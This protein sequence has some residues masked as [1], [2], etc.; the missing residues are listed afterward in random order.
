MDHQY[1]ASE[2]SSYNDYLTSYAGKGA[3]K[4]TKEIWSTTARTAG[5]TSRAGNT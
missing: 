4:M 5:H 1:E 3:D 2:M